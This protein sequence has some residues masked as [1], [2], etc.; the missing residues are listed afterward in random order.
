MI[1][2]FLTL[3]SFSLE[4]L[5]YFLESLALFLI[6]CFL[7]NSR[8]AISLYLKNL[9]ILPLLNFLFLVFIWFIQFSNFLKEQDSSRYVDLK[10]F[11]VKFAKV[12]HKGILT[13]E[14]LLAHVTHYVFSFLS[15]QIIRTKWWFL[16]LLARIILKSFIYSDFFS[17]KIK[18]YFINR[19]IW[20]ERILVLNAARTNRVFERWRN[21][22]INRFL[23]FHHESQA[24][25]TDSS[26][27]V[28]YLV[29]WVRIDSLAKIYRRYST[30]GWCL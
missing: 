4:Y 24:V 17:F 13:Q 16:M 6:L 23:F 7:L 28:F 30:A 15:F 9:L 22:P 19:D 12:I 1:W 21:H 27:R 3:K 20:F 2:G 8:L 5:K 18:D 10:D 26:N 25:D 14:G 29:G 11:L